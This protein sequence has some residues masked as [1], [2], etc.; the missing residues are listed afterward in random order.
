MRLLIHLLLLVLVPLLLVHQVYLPQS[1]TG[2]GHSI[3][4]Q[5]IIFAC[6]G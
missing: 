2:E 5:I 4:G 3:P 1:F 6:C